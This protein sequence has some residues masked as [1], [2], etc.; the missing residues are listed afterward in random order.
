MTPDQEAT[1]GTYTLVVELREDVTVDVGALGA[2]AFDPGWYAY[3][4]SANGHGGFARVDRHCE[5]AAGHRDSRHWHI[6]YLLGH[7]DVTVDTVTKTAGVDGECAVA[8]A[9]DCGAVD[10]FGCSDC[11]CGSH[12]AFSPQRAPLLGRIRRAHDGIRGGD[13]A[14]TSS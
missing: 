4:G 5:L 9:L 12:L 2:V 11:C 6:D 8:T 3:V 1:G 7:P 14:A 10:G 13:G